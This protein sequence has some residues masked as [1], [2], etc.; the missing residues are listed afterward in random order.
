M[1]QT[2][3]VGRKRWA[4]S[5]R[6]FQAPEQVRQLPVCTF[7]QS[8]RGRTTP[9]GDLLFIKL[10]LSPGTTPN[11]AAYA[12]SLRARGTRDTRPVASQPHRLFPAPSP[13]TRIAL[14]GHPL[15]SL[16]RT[17]PPKQ[18]GPTSHNPSLVP[19]DA[20]I[21]EYTVVVSIVEAT[22][23]DYFRE[24]HAPHTQKPHR[25]LA[26][27]WQRSID[28]SH[29]TG[30]DCHA[31]TRRGTMLR[32]SHAHPSLIHCFVLPSSPSSAK[33]RKEKNRNPT[34]LHSPSPFGCPPTVE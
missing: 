12:P 22:S 34:S 20:C 18:A 9:L 13:Q 17:A 28:S 14:S 25:H 21:R 24:N 15:P 6:A 27:A 26:R 32:S 8:N 30:Q 31:H 16:R 3:L 4:S 19:A 11:A 23:C 7:D 29:P 2:L 10:A 5:N 33:T 1:D